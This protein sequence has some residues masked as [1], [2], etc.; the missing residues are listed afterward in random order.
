MSGIMRKASSLC[1]PSKLFLA[2]TSIYI[3]YTIVV[4]YKY[5]IYPICFDPARCDVFITLVHLAL[6]V[7]IMILFTWILDVIC[8]YGHNV[9]AWALFAVILTFRHLN[10]FHLELIV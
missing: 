5:G 6:S 1:T 4:A 2:I 8:S 7:I 3:M 10:N 9:V